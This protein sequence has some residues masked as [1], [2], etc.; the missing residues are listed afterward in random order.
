MSAQEGRLAPVTLVI[1]AAPGG[2]V[3]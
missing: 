3:L 2:V 1:G